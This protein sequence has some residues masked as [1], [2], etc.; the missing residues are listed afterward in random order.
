MV[1]TGICSFR[2][3]TPAKM[4]THLIRE[5]L[6][7]VRVAVVR[8]ALRAGGRV[9]VGRRARPEDVG[10]VDVELDEGAHA[11]WLLRVNVRQTMG[12]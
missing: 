8:E 4:H 2:R 10:D 11:F 6:R 5:E 7:K 1:K 9:N 3:H 12:D